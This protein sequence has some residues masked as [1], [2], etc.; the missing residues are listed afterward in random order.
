[1]KDN[2]N[3]LVADYEEV[4]TKKDGGEENL[5]PGY[6]KLRKPIT[7]DGKLIESISLDL[8]SLTGEDIE[9]AEVQFM[10]NNPS[11]AAQTP[12]KEMSKGFLSIVAAKA[13]KKPLEFIKKLSAPDYSQVT[14]QVQVFLMTG[15]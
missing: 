8:D 1:M 13:A 11:I 10:T 6:V 14:T 5:T 15:N 2:N 3:A 9:K 7:F 4:P 12:L